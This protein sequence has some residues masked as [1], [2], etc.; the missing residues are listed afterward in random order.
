MKQLDDTATTRKLYQHQSFV[1]D[2][3]IV[4]SISGAIQNYWYIH[5]HVFMCIAIH[6]P[7]EFSFSR[8]QTAYGSK[9]EKKA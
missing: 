8:K 7:K 3:H 5:A 6:H 2:S 1:C 9:N 4:S